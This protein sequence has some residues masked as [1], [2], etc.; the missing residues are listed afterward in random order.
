MKCL[1]LL[2]FKRKK[3][4]KAHGYNEVQKQ[5]CMKYETLDVA[6]T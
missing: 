2:K 4:K 1:I 3:K 6:I 5:E